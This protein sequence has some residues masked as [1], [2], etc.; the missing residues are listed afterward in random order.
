MSRLSVQASGVL[1]TIGELLIIAA[2]MGAR[3]A[4]SLPT[5]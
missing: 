4:R 2:D 5:A 3:R 1:A